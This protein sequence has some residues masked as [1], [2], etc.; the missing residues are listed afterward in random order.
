[1]RIAYEQEIGRR[2]LERLAEAY[3]RF[4]HGYDETPLLI[5]NAA[6]IDPIGNEQHYRMLL[7]EIDAARSGR[8]FFNPLFS[9]LG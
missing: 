9:A 4:F 7:N 2:Y 5:V 1:M 6:T 8:R 3:A